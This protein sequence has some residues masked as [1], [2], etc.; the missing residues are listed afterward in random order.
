MIIKEE[1]SRRSIIA[2]PHLLRTLHPDIAIGACILAFEI[3]PELSLRA[4]AYI[5]EFC[6]P[7]PRGA[8]SSKP[9]I[10]LQ[11]GIRDGLYEI[12]GRGRM[13]VKRF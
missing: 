1:V 11:H 6:S 2:G 8:V 9:S 3:C 10:R 5:G 12:F 7:D 4:R 13:K